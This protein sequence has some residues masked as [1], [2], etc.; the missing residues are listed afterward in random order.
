M[1]LTKAGSY[2]EPIQLQKT[3]AER[4]PAQNP[5]VALQ[6]AGAL[7]RVSRLAIEFPLTRNKNYLYT[8][9][10]VVSHGTHPALRDPVVRRIQVLHVTWCQE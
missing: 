7:S 3:I 5:D 1:R 9:M 6:Y 4:A 8:C 10:L 2:T